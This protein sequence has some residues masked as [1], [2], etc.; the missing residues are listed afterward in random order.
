M[1]TL[2][3]TL[4]RTANCDATAQTSTT[5]WPQAPFW[6]NQLLIIVSK[7]N[8]CSGGLSTAYLKIVSCTWP[9]LPFLFFNVFL[10]C[11]CRLFDLLVTDKFC[12]ILKQVFLSQRIIVQTFVIVPGAQGYIS[13]SSIF[14]AKKETVHEVLL[15]GKATG[16]CWG[17]TFP[18]VYRKRLWQGLGSL[19]LLHHISGISVTILFRHLVF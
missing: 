13:I 19:P 16:I 6:V 10:I 4:P 18:D 9:T 1:H 2:P 3:N 15:T 7:T 11:V 12:Y 14:K 8:I 5:E 17:I